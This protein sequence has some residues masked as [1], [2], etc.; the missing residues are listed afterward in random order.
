MHRAL[1]ACCLSIWLWGCAI[2]PSAI[3]SDT[4]G[5]GEV[6]EDTTNK[7]LVLNV[8]RARDKAPL[9]FADIPLMRQSM[10]QSFSF[11]WLDFIGASRAPPTT[12]DSVTLG[13]SVQKTP[14]FDL[15]HLHSKDFITGITSPIDPKIVKYWLDR[16]L[17]RR[18]VLLIFFS[19]VE[20]VETR[21]EKGPVN[22]IRVANAPREAVDIIKNRK[23]AFVGTEALRCDTQS[24]FERYLKLLNKVKTFFAHNY[25]E[26]RLLARGLQPGAPEDSK[27]LQAFAALDQTKV[28]LVYDRERGT[29]SVYSLSSEQKVAFCFYDD[30]QPAE[31]ASAQMEFIESG[32]ESGPDRRNCFQSVVDVRAEE[33]RTRAV[34]PSPIFFPGAAAVKEESRYC[35]I[36]N[37]FSG[38]V[39]S[40]AAKPGGYPR[41][42]LRLFIRSVGEIFQFLGDL[43][44]YQDEVRRH[45][46]EHSHL[47]LKLNTPVTFGYCGDL[48]EPGCDDIFIRLDG[49]TCNARFSLTYRDKEYHISNFDPPG[50]TYR[51]G[52]NCRADYTPRRD[53]TLEILSVLHQLVGLH[54]SATDVRSTPSVQVLP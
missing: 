52:L 1:L 11:G 10:Q 37:R 35:G 16:G 29:Y 2:S 26:R 17:D 23:E 50:L 19:G 40:P 12:R 32:R 43:L 20:I 7:L 5:F 34:S 8:L 6:I 4:M 33:T 46:D 38:T 42:E 41:L 48:H 14:S 18:L 21:S 47:G 53:H 22:T 51:Q 3:Q 30:A 44:H 13:A 49:D 27:N 54:K 25:R 39:P 36:Y 31:P 45:L 15:N 24:D 9:H 28:Q